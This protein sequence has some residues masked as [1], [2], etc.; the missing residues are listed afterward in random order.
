MYSLIPQGRGTQ[1]ATA[2]SVDESAMS[3]STVLNRSLIFVYEN[4]TRK[5]LRRPSGCEPWTCSH[6]ILFQVSPSW[7]ICWAETSAWMVAR[8]IRSHGDMVCRT[9]WHLFLCLVPPLPYRKPHLCHFQ[10]I[11]QP[12]SPLSSHFDHYFLDDGLRR[13]CASYTFCLI[14]AS[15]P[16][17]LYYTT[18]TAV[19]PP[20]DV[21]A[22]TRVKF[23]KNRDSVD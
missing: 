18:V 15:P 20:N 7:V 11:E 17:L 10:W 23:R 1:S 21:D 6:R 2:A 3:A 14:Q 19:K 9:L 13:L 8:A 5:W 16:F 22:Q 12:N 4:G